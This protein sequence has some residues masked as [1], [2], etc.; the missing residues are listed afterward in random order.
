MS[1]NTIPCQTI[2][3]IIVPIANGG[4]RFS[5]NVLF[6]IAKQQFIAPLQQ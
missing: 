5:E 4:I 6:R 1:Q 3:S 2:A